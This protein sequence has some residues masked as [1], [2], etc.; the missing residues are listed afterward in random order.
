MGFYADQVL[1]RAMDLVLRG[2]EL[3]AIRA[4]VASDLSGEVLEVG[5]GTGRNVAHYPPAVTRVL[6]V[7]PAKVGRKIAARRVAASSVPIEYIGLDGQSLPLPAESVDH[8]LTT[9][10]LCTIPDVERA[11][12]EIKRALRPSGTLHFIEHGRSPDS[13][14]A[15]WQDRLTPIQR[16]MAGGC[17]LNRPIDTLIA[18]S[19][20]D[21]QRLDTY[22]L[23]GLKSFSYSYEGVATK[24]PTR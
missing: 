8:A 12:H 13:K 2:D 20:L 9:W 18:D 16:R 19:G 22:Y 23:R 6:A 10:T 17:H 21:L 5:F 15:R 3:N 7:D 24:T 1:P 4:R 14:V 11:L